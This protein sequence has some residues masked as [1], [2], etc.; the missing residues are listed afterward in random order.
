[1]S[2]WFITV[3]GSWCLFRH[4]ILMGVIKP[5]GKATRALRNHSRSWQGYGKGGRRGGGGGETL[6]KFSTGSSRSAALTGA[7]RRNTWLHCCRHCISVGRD[8]HR[9]LSWLSD[10]HIIVKSLVID[11]LRL[12]SGQ[13]VVLPPH[14]G[15][16]VA[17]LD[18]QAQINKGCV[19]QLPNAGAI[20]QWNTG[21]E[22]LPNRSSA[23]R[24]GFFAFV[25]D[26]TATGQVMKSTD[27]KK[28]Y[29][30]TAAKKGKSP[31]LRILAP[32]MWAKMSH[33][34]CRSVET[35]NTSSRKTRS[36]LA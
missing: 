24:G 25:S 36:L 7:D 8:Q 23:E 28:N 14:N 32:E 15:C 26:T 16:A 31:C 1:M 20:F 33:L 6:L 3:R 30:D 29:E 10:V 17:A 18:L 9:K 11:G 13:T 5:G 4:K 22:D 19:R 35:F 12:G 27:R 34:R 21:E 2:V